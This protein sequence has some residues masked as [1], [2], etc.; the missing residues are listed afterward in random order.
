MK[1]NLKK[2][3][4]SYRVICTTDPFNASRHC[5]FK[6]N[7]NRT[8]GVKVMEENLTLKEARASLLK[9]YNEDLTTRTSLVSAK[10][11]SEAVKKHADNVA[12]SASLRRDHTASYSFDIFTYSIVE[13]P[14][15]LYCSELSVQ[16]KSCLEE[17]ESND[18][19]SGWVLPIF[20]EIVEN[21]ICL[22]AGSPCNKN[23]SFTNEENCKYVGCVEQWNL[24]D[25]IKENGR[26][27]EIDDV[28]FDRDEQLDFALDN[29]A[30][31][32]VDEI[33]K[34]KEHIIEAF[35]G[36]EVVFD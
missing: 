7:Q 1:T 3:E 6:L 31:D 30:Y 10:T 36:Y 13:A 18:F 16:Y 23:S 11:W 20:A 15:K 32:N 27:E 2:V 4:K 21:S 35:E 33:E 14:A 8:L 22:S 25:Y 26:E 29:L 24:I 12:L 28:D 17:A 34:M 9:M 19:F 5:G